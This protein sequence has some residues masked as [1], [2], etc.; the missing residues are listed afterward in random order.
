MSQITDDALT[1]AHRFGFGEPAWQVL[2]SDPRGWVLGQ[3]RTP[4]VFP[5]EG[6]MNTSDLGSITRRVQ[7][8]TPGLDAE[9]QRQLRELVRRANLSAWERRW[10]HTL[11]T[12]TPVAERWVQFWSNHFCVSGTRGIVT[13]LVQPFEREAIRPHAFGRF[14]DLLRA[15]TLHPAMLYYLDNAQSI[16]PQSRLGARRARGLNENLA[17]ELLELHTLGVDGG[18]SQADV[19]ETARLLTGWTVTPARVLA[20][21]RA[22]AAASAASTAAPAL[23]P[24]AAASSPADPTDGQTFRT[25]FNPNWHE[26]GRRN[27][28]GRSYAEE[29]PAAL[30]ALLLDLSR[31]PATARHVSRQ[32]V[33]HFVADEPPARLVDALAARWQATD[34]DLAAVA[35]AL[36][37]H[38]L[39]WQP[40]PAKVKRPEEWMLSAHRVLGIPLGPPDRFQAAMNTLGQPTGMAPSPQGWSDRGEDWLGPDALMKRVEWAFRFAQRD[41]ARLTGGA[42]RTAAANNAMGMTPAS[43]PAASGASTSLGG[44]RPADWARAALGERLREETRREVERADS[45]AQALALW[46]VSPEFLRR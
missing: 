3:L 18:Y 36:F 43:A 4:A 15:A 6:L 25:E 32:L 29:G 26:P 40:G 27:V 41:A 7:A 16:G 19:T 9:Q 45:G 23:A 5:G 2:A 39:A 12:P 24:A 14:I 35:E 42:S 20:A 17:R 33:R 37:Q 13:P 21:A 8:N 30:E 11:T 38:P 10:Q 28:M 46:L 34:G 22:A 1:A 44:A 31:H